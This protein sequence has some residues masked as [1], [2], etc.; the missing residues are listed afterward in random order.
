M[1]SC[2]QNCLPVVKDQAQ[3]SILLL[4]AKTCYATLSA[5]FQKARTFFSS[6]EFKIMVQ[7]CYFRLYFGTETVSCLLLQ[8]MSIDMDKKWR[9]L[10]TFF[11]VLIL[12]PQKLFKNYYSQC[13]LKKFVWHLCYNVAGAFRVRVK[14]LSNDFTTLKLTQNDTE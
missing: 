10:R 7:F 13:S 14:T 9:K 3:I 1:T 2:R 5:P 12:C 6:I 8:R 4:K 11:Q